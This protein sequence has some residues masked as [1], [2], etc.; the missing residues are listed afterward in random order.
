MVSTPSCTSFRSISRESSSG[1]ISLDGG[2]DRV[3]LL[4]EQVP[5]LHRIV[6]IG[7]VGHS[8]SRRRAR[9]RSRGSWRS[10]IR[11]WRGRTRSP[12]TSA[13]KTGHAGGGEAL[14]DALQGHR[15][16]GAGRARDQAVA[17]GA[18]EFELLAWPP[19]P[20]PMKMPS[21]S[22]MSS[23]PVRALMPKR[24]NAQGRRGCESGP[25]Q[26]PGDDR[27]RCP[28]DRARER[29]SCR[30]GRSSS[31]AAR[32][33][34]RVAASTRRDVGGGAGVGTLVD[35]E[36]RRRRAAGPSRPRRSIGST[37]V[38]TTPRTSP[39]DLQLR[40]MRRASAAA[41][42]RP[43]ALRRLPAGLRRLVAGVPPSSSSPPPT[44]SCARAPPRSGA[45]RPSTVTVWRLPSRII[46][47][48]TRAADAGVGDEIAQRLVGRHSLAADA[49]RRRRPAGCRRFAAAW[50]GST[51]R[52]SSPRSLRQAERGGDVV[53]DRLDADAEIAALDRCA[54]A[55]R[56]DRPAWPARRGSRSR[57]RHCRRS[58]RSARC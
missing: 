49:R 10:A 53:V 56:V 57:C 5:E 38:T 15:L 30:A 12:F 32:G 40:A 34:R 3:A 1:P 27:G 47:I 21:S 14:D 39:D 7:P 22:A 8:R 6:G 35:R 18:L 37:A 52:I 28:T 48:G 20:A 50:P 2:A 25:R 26:L 46:S 16:A 11:P 24:P 54:A 42:G 36:D 9:R 4:A 13:T 58:A 29:P 19:P 17:V 31:D 41:T 43:S 23:S 55:Q 51:A 33:R 45:C 44:V